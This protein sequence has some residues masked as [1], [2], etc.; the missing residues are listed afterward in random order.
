MARR[1]TFTLTAA[2]PVVATTAI[3][4]TV[5]GLL[6]YDWFSIDA[7][8]TGVAGGTL[9]VY[10]QREVDA[11]GNGVWADWCH[12]PQFAAAGAAV[13]YCAQ[14]GADK[15]IHVVEQGTAAAAGTPA[16]AANT[17]IG[18]HPGNKLRMVFVTGASTTGPAKT[19]VVKI[20][21]W[22]AD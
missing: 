20:T 15:T 12:F 17:L 16:L 1:R 3:G 14:S 10:L 22:N 7:A 5:A 18:G 19:Q 9:D 8:L 11:D 2:T 4:A 21:G 13:E 6:D